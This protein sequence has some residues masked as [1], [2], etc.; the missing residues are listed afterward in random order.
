[1]RFEIGT[2]RLAS[3]K[4]EGSRHQRH[5]RALISM[6]FTLRH[7]RPAGIQTSPGI[8]VD[9]SESGTGAIVRSS[10]RVGETVCIDLRLRHCWLGAIG[11]V[12]YC[13]DVRSGFEFVGLSTDERSQIV[14]TCRYR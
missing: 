1:M 10:L 12:R 4:R 7:L 2:T 6:P 9:L 8:S 5:P 11:I 3:Q 13:S 14:N